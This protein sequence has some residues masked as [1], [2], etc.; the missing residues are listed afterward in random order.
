MNK[1]ARGFLSISVPRVVE[2]LMDSSASVSPGVWQ[3]RPGSREHERKPIGMVFGG[4]S[5][6]DGMLDHGLPG[7]PKC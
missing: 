7:M 5:H 3:D 6:G 2:N 1:T 4:L